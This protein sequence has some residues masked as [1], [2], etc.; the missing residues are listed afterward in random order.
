[1]VAMLGEEAIIKPKSADRSG[2]NGRNRGGLVGFCVD[3]DL[4]GL[5]GMNIM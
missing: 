1:M 3:T 2:S 5:L 4:S